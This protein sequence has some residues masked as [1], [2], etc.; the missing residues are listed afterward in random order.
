MRPVPAIISA[1]V[2]LLVALGGF[3]LYSVL[4]TGSDDLEGPSIDSSARIEIERLRAQIEGLN[5]RINELEEDLRNLGLQVET[6]P[7]GDDSPAER[8]PGLLGEYA[9][10]VVIPDRRNRNKGLTVVTPSYLESLFGR[11]RD[12]LSD[13]CEPVTNPEFKERL[14][15]EQVGPIRVNMMEPA[16]RSL[17]EVFERIRFA[18]P[19]LYDQINTSGS[20][21]VRQ[22]RGTNGR[23]SSHAFGLAIDLNIE[24]HLDN[25]TDGKTQLGLILLA[26]FFKEAGWIW[27]AGFNREDS[28]HFEVSREKI[29]EWQRDGLI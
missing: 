18:D 23:L 20:L 28:M 17:G 4:G 13:D 3:G 5:A 9:K 12:V 29:E 2:V 15:L 16:A 6:R 11:P 1:L 14:V 24:G 7:Q 21:C 8:D 27:G 19:V 22:I 10:V 26:D 25:F